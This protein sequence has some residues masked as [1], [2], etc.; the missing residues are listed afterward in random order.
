MECLQQML[1]KKLMIE[2]P[3]VLSP[4]VDRVSNQNDVN[5]IVIFFLFL[6]EKFSFLI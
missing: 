2:S 4:E 1:S 3:S 5:V 6:K